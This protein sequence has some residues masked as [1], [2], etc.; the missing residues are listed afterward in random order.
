MHRCVAYNNSTINLKIIDNY[1][2]LFGKL[3]G[4]VMQKYWFLRY[5]AV[6]R[7]FNFS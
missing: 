7:S 6:L 4:Y 1:V 2:N 5:G 3:I